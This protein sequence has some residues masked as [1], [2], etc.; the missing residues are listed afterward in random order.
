MCRAAPPGLLDITIYITGK[1]T[2]DE[3]EVIEGFVTDD[4]R[5][6][7]PTAAEE[8]E[9]AKAGSEHQHTEKLAPMPDRRTS[10]STIVQHNAKVTLKSGRPDFD[11]VVEEEVARTDYDEWLVFGTCGPTPM[12]NSLAGTSP[13]LVVSCNSNCTLTGAGHSQTP[14][15]APSGRPRSF[16]GSSEETSRFV[17]NCSAGKSL[18]L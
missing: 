12:V 17:K 16:A 13:G 8:D 7:R 4:Q 6:P 10:E 2:A 5:K 18:L 15:P 3:P 14:S 9:K 11:E 1:R